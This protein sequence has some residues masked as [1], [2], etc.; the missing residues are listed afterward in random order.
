MPAVVDHI[1]RPTLSE[2]IGLKP[3]IR[4]PQE[5]WHALSNCI[6][7]QSRVRRFYRHTPVEGIGGIDKYIF[8]FDR[9]SGIID[10]KIIH[11]FLMVGQIADRLKDAV[12]ASS[13]A[14]RKKELARQS[15]ERVQGEAAQH[16]HIPDYEIAAEPGTQRYVAE[17]TRKR[18]LDA[19]DKAAANLETWTANAE[20]ASADVAAI[21]A[22]KGAGAEEHH[23]F[24]LDDLASGRVLPSFPK[25]EAVADVA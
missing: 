7:R 1:E 2:V 25:A 13:D 17:E 21:Q 23:R 11:G 24:T 4:I 14:H 9:A 10:M 3:L 18:F 20:A 5:A 16:I 15:L 6:A 19:I 8:R 12:A 22:Q